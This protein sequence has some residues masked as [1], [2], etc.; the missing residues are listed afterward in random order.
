[1][2]LEKILLVTIIGL[3]TISAISPFIILSVVKDKAI[4]GQIGDTFGGTTAPL[5]NI[6]AILAV[7]ITY[8]Y[9]RRNDQRNNHKEQ[10][11]E[12]F[13][14]LKEELQ[15]IDY[16]ITINH[17]SAGKEIKQY[18]GADAIH[19]IIRASN[20]NEYSIEIKELQPFNS[21]VNVYEYLNLLLKDLAS[22]NTLTSNDKKML[23]TQLSLFY[24]NNLLI[25]KE[26]RGDEICRH[27]GVKHKIPIQIYNQLIEIEK[28]IR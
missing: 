7:V 16:K 20:N 21:I 2:R 26:Q 6:S 9:Q 8:M 27:H 25:D 18:I 22:D 12:N 23:L 3:L 28:H 10:I 13:K 17:K 5:I 19:E 4:A 15:K 1:M 11:I 14:N 24:L